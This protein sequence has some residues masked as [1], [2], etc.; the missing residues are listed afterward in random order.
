MSL[1][2][3]RTHS[4]ALVAQIEAAGVVVGDA[5]PPTVAY[6]WQ[7][8]PGQSVFVPYAIVYPLTQSFDGGLGCPD[9]DSDFE[10]QVTCVGE[11]REQADWVRAK[12]DAALIGQTLTVS[13]RYVPRIR[14]SG[15][16]GT[17][18]DDTTQP[19]LFISTPRYAAMST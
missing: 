8:A 2:D 10:W 5:A 15:G 14:S 12:V 19:P 3:P 9:A 18:R 7:G 17:R 4:D 1:A 11:S 13:G 6:G 16:A